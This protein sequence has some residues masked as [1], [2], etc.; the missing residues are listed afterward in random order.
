[1][2]GYDRKES[3]KKE[4]CTTKKLFPELKAPYDS[5]LQDTLYP[6]EALPRIKAWIKALQESLSED[7]KEVKPGV[8]IHKTV[9]LYPNVYFGENIIIMEKCELRPGA[10][11]RENVLA[12][13]GSVLG[14]SCEFKNAV[15]FPHV[16]TPHYNYVGDSILGEYSH[17]GAGALTSNVKSDKTLLTIHFEDGEIETGLKKFGAILSDHVEVGCQ[18]VLNPGT[19]IFSHTN[20]YPLSAVR[21]IIPGGSIYK[22]KNTIVKK[23]GEE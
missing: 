22:D 9:K 1:M 2:K 4:A 19:I 8:F 14:N 17:L 15:L 21:G 18:S 10:F 16:Q 5:L 6:W 23:R 20:I 7:F 3:M 12:G 13:A 11:L